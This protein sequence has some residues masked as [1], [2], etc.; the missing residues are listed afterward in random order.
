[1]ASHDIL[2]LS[3]SPPKPF[4]AYN[5]SS[6]PLPSLKELTQ[7]KAP[8]LRTGSRAAPI[9]QNA[10]ASFTSAASLVKAT[11]FSIDTWDDGE[12][13]EE[14]PKL[15]KPKARKPATKKVENGEEKVAKAPRNNAKDAVN[16]EPKKPRKPRAKVT[17]QDNG[18]T[19][20]PK[21]SAPR[22]PRAKKVEKESSAKE[23]AKEKPA[24]KPRSKKADGESQTTLA[25]GKV[26]KSS[27]ILVNKADKAVKSNKL[28]SATTELQ[29]PFVDS[30][31]LGLVEAVQR[32]TDWTPPMATGKTIDVTPVTG[33][34]LDFETNSGGS[35]QAGVRSKAFTDLFG[36][37]GFSKL[38]ND[39]VGKKLLETE[40]PRKRKLIELVKTS[41]S[42][43]AAA[44]PK[45]KAPKKKARTITAQATSAYAE[46]EE[47]P[48]KPAPLLQY[49][50]RQT[51]ERVT[52]D[53]FKVPRKPRS[54][55]PV[56][57]ALKAK[58]GSVEAPILLS[59][60]SALKQSG[61]QDF[62]FGTSSQLARED[63]PTL[64]RDL[65]EAM[66]A[67][68]KLD[69]DDPFAHIIYEPGPTDHGKALVSAKCNLWSAAARDTAGDLLE[70][71]MV[72][73]VDSPIVTNQAAPSIVPESAESLSNGVE[74]GVWHDIEE[75]SEQP[76]Q[77]IQNT[78]QS[79]IAIGPV[80]AAIRAG[81]LSSP[82]DKSK[83]TKTKKTD[84]S[85]S[86][87]A[88]SPTRR[89]KKASKSTELGIP[90]FS[91]YTTAQLAKEIASYRFKPVKSRDGMI[92]LLEK[93][94]EGKNR[95]AL[96]AIGTN[97]ISQPPIESSKPLAPPSSQMSAASPKCPRGRP[98]KDSTATTPPKSKVG[99][100]KKSTTVEFLEMDSD[101]PLSQI[102]TPKKSKKGKEVAEDISDSET[103]LR[104]SP[105]RRQASQTKTP[106]LPLKPS[107]DLEIDSPSLS[108][109]SS[110]ARLFTHI[111]RAVKSAPPSKDPQKP[112]WH[113]KILLYDPIILED[114]TVWLNTGALGK[115]GWDGEV[116]PKEVKKW[117]EG[118]S[119]CCLWRENL[120]GG[121][122]S[123][124]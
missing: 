112:S 34:R 17:D 21:E 72:D 32:R 88:K 93:C 33:D 106:P 7:K 26:T 31:D 68:N 82:L 25:K 90:D 2:I 9:P 65:H 56:K 38:D 87:R 19:D 89:S 104:P 14:L 52:S 102:R 75:S 95:I 35:I 54:K 99:R 101:T 45:E 84:D 11:S 92:T 100:P 119:I 105:P 85:I 113:E 36:S 47:V 55:S 43:A 39:D 13:I 63:S 69:D 18:D 49:F 37:F 83:S 70:V 48:A 23:G 44:S 79:T 91:A 98:R 71:E 76:E 1:M 108:P 6:S 42:N 61:N 107:T 81:L 10:S 57:G 59:P 64:L 111:T 86:R 115:V 122:R 80:E 20:I 120:R 96:G 27:S 30:V 117:C 67:S 12:S 94:W 5:M 97:I 103:E 28:K 4:R 40:K 77:D 16:G 62:V 114:L 15:P 29:D 22:K 118:R 51:T 78:T 109:T 74:E 123:R 58:K 3:S 24:R 46:E 50:S 66:Q 124:Y 110:Q 8:A 121:S 60:E 116:E 41:V 73:L 53:G